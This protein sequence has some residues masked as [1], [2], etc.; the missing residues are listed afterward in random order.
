MCLVCLAEQGSVLSPFP[1]CHLKQRNVLTALEMDKEEIVI[2]EPSGN[3][4]NQGLSRRCHFP[5]GNIGDAGKS[6][7]S[8]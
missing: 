2:M 7:H 3:E 8:S 6:Y 1:G 4:G 5:A